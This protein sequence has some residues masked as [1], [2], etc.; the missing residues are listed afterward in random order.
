MEGFGQQ[1]QVR[2]LAIVEIQTIAMLTSP[3]WPT[4]TAVR[5]RADVRF[6]RISRSR[7][8]QYALILPRCVLM[9]AKMTDVRYLIDRRAGHAPLSA[10]VSSSPTYPATY[11]TNAIVATKSRFT[12]CPE[13]ASLA[14]KRR[15]R[16][17]ELITRRAKTMLIKKCC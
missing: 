17:L 6:P 10:W 1:S 14:A 4:R 5:D 12:R 15:L 7:A 11:P 9:F 13:S 16:C 2:Y 8:V 3:A